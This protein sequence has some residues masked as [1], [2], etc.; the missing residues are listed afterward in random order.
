MTASRVRVLGSVLARLTPQQ[1]PIPSSPLCPPP[2]HSA[3]VP[4]LLD[5]AGVVYEVSWCLPGW[6]LNPVVGAVY[7]PEFYAG[8]YGTRAGALWAGPE[9]CPV[10]T[11]T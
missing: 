9:E 3:L 8:K 6:K 2:P 10:G 5:V 7:G 1:Q 4:E 11:P